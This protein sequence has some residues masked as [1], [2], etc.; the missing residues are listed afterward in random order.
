MRI[1]LIGSLLIPLASSVVAGDPDYLAPDALHAAGLV[2]FWQL[3]LPLEKDQQLQDVHLVDDQLYL[4]TQDGYVFAVHAL[5]GV[6]RWLQPVT[7]SG[8]TL[9][10]PCHVGEQVVFVT[11]SDLQIYDRRTGD[12]VSR[13]DL[14]FSAGSAAITDGTQ[15]LVGGMDRRFYSLDPRTQY[16]EWKVL[17][18]A[19]ITSTPAL[20]GDSVFFA[21]EAGT[22]FAC[23]RDGRRVLRWQYSAYDRVSADLVARDEGVYVPSRDWSLYL[24]DLNYG[25]VRW[26]ARFSGPLYEPP[27]VTP[28]VAYQYTPADG[29]VAVDT[30]VIG[31]PDDRLRW[32]L[33]EGRMALT[34]HEGQTYVLTKD[35]QVL[36]VNTKTGELSNAIPAPGFVLG[37][38][39]PASATIYVAAPDGRVFC[40]RAR[41]ATP[42]TAQDVLAALRLSGQKADSAGATSQPTTRPTPKAED[43]LATRN[44]GTPAGGKSNVT[45]QFQ[46]ASGEPQE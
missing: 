24:L 6:I 12:P 34:V 29:L 21:T 43:P 41:G 18:D 33:P 9:R 1:L 36:A 10:R 23:S 5:T 45:K 37:I 32:K 7:R 30:T 17:T 2:K 44:K 15:L 19:A 46:P 25:N 16:V 11:P 39:A 20:A 31:A 8:Y 26:R 28:E 22:V 40:G 42:P 4:A 13:T 27:V 38:P 3:S 14:R 35:Q